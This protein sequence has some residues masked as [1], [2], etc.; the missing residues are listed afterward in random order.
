MTANRDADN[1]SDNDG[2]VYVKGKNYE[3]R[4]TRV[5]AGVIQINSKGGIDSDDDSGMLEKNDRRITRIVNNQPFENE[6]SDD[7][8]Y[9]QSNNYGK[10]VNINRKNSDDSY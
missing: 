9:K 7:E 5:G 3:S 8:S 4:K 6:N 1:I 10:A 2:S